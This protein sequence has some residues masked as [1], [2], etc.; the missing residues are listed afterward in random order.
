[1]KN[2]YGIL[3]TVTDNECVTVKYDYKLVDET[4]L[5]DV[6]SSYNEYSGISLTVYSPDEL[7]NFELYCRLLGVKTERIN[8]LDSITV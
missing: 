3:L 2:K 7:N 8:V 1:M 6:E 4:S 5:K